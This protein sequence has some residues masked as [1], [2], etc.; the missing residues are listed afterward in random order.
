MGSVMS[1]AKNW[2]M[3]GIGGSF[4]PPG[5]GPMNSSSAPLSSA[6]TRTTS[7]PSSQQPATE[8]R[9]EKAPDDE[10]EEEEGSEEEEESDT[11]TEDEKDA[12]GVGASPMA[13]KNVAVDAAFAFLSG[14]EEAACI[15]AHRFK[16][17]EQM[18]I[19]LEGV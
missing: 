12:E 8:R 5:Q 10:E 16:D 9:V 11:D 7:T 14:E 15:T 1:A 19:C 18:V 4:L 6:A 3:E 13:K 2:W 17:A